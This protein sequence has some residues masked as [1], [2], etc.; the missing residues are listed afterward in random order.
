MTRERK[1]QMLELV[2]DVCKVPGV[3]VDITIG[4]VTDDDIFL[5][6]LRDNNSKNWTCTIYRRD[7]KPDHK[8]GNITYISDMEFDAAE[9]RLRQILRETWEGSNGDPG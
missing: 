8:S 7:D 3:K 6:D 1:L 4:N 2:L 5:N 9:A